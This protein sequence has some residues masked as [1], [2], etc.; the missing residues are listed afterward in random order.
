MPSGPASPARF[1]VAQGDVPFGQPV[2]LRLDMP[3]CRRRFDLMATVIST[4]AQVTD[5]ELESVPGELMLLIDHL[6]RAELDPGGRLSDADEDSSASIEIAIEETDAELEFTDAD[7]SGYWASLFTPASADMQGELDR[8][9]VQAIALMC[10][11]DGPTGVLRIWSGARR[12]VGYIQRGTPLLMLAEPPGDEGNLDLALIGTPE[13]DLEVFGE[14]IDR[15]ERTGDPLAAIL[16]EMRAIDH[17]ALLAL[18]SD[19]ARVLLDA[20][21]ADSRGRFAF[22]ATEVPTASDGVTVDVAALLIAA[23]ILLAE[24]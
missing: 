15:Q 14:A 12:I 22:W 11:E 9:G 20:L 4:S 23:G 2:L 17:A 18:A 7:D 24:E 13:V 3:F 1:R 16:L 19:E 21:K 6:E 5:L 10:T 8:A